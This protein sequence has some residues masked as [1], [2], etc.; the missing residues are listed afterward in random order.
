MLI[1]RSYSHDGNYLLKMHTLNDVQLR[2]IGS[3]KCDGAFR[4]VDGSH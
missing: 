3:G 2:V 4:S 1:Q